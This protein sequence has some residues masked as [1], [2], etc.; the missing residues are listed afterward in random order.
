MHGTHSF[1]FTP[2]LFY[3][4]STVSLHCPSLLKS[5]MDVPSASPSVQISPAVQPSSLQFQQ[6][7]TEEKKKKH[8][9]TVLWLWTCPIKLPDGVSMFQVVV[10]QQ[11][12]YT[13]KTD[14]F[15]MILRPNVI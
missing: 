6:P 8:P 13:P 12:G 3:Q 10:G 9:V 15:F 1:D 11:S 2:A 7:D 14:H 4:A 5:V